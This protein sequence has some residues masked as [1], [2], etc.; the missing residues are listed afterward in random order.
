MAYQG[1]GIDENPDVDFPVVTIS[2]GQPGA[3]PA[4]METEITRKV[5]DALVGIEGLD[6]ITSTVSDG[7]SL[8]VAEFEVGTGIDGAMNDIRDAVGRIRQTLPADINEPAISNPNFAGQPFIT[9]TVSSDTRSVAELSDLIDDDITRSLLTVPGVGQVTRSGG[10][11]REIRVELDP[12]RLRAVGATVEHVNAQLRALNINLPGG[13]ARTGAQEQTIRTLGSVQRVEDLKRLQIALPNGSTARLD[14]LGTVSDDFAEVAQIARLNGKPVVGFNV[15]RAK[16]AA[17]VQTEEATV[18]HVEELKKTLPP[19]IRIEMVRTSADYTRSAFHASMDALVL[20]A[21]LAVIVIFL[22]LRNW[23]ATLISALAIPLS[24]IATFWV[25]QHL[26]YTLNGITLLGLTLVVGILV[27]DAIVDLENIYRH[28]AMGKSP[29]KAAFEATDEIG[30]AI[31]ATTAT[32]VAVFVPVA[33]MGGIPGMF[34]RS[35]G[36]TV[37]AAV[38]FS[39]L[40]ARTLTP[41]MAAYMLPSKVKHEEEGGSWYHRLYHRVLKLALAHRWWTMVGAVVIFVGSMALVPLIPKGFMSTGDIGQA[42]VAVELPAGSTLDQTDAV[43]QEVTRLLMERPET[44]LVFATAGAS[45]GAS[46][47]TS[48]GATVANSASVNVVL[49]PKHERA[50][51]LNEFEDALRPAFA[52][53]PGARVQFNQYGAAGGAKPVNILLRSSDPEALAKTSTQLLN[54]MRA[55]PELRDVTSSAAEMRPEVLIRPDPARAAEQGVS[56]MAVARVARLATQGEA[57]FNMPKFNAGDKQ[58]NIRVKLKDAVRYDLEAIGDLLVPGKAGMV[59]L[60]TVA[61]VSLGSGPVQIDRYDRARQVTFAANLTAGNLGAAVAKVQALPALKD[62]PPSVSQGTVGESK[63]MI[64]IFTQFALALG[65]AVL[66]IYAVLVLLFGGFMQPL[67]IMMALPLSIG[68]AMLGL[69]AF[70]KEMGMMALIGIVMLMGLVCKNSILLVEYAIKARHDGLPRTEALLRSGRD[71]LRPILMTTIAM[72]A[73]MMPIALAFGEGTERLSP[74]AV[75][76]I[77]GLITSTIFTLVVVPAAFTIVD[78]VQRFFW[79]LIGK[80]RP[81]A[82]AERPEEVVIS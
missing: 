6:H 20:G 80:P 24:I 75:A 52:Q 72:I 73:G 55:M 32:I 28:I 50:L 8:T 62:A 19:D 9:Y 7:V 34:F 11:N 54:E 13:S 57:D 66:L 60:R 5:E 76:V 3:A 29:L 33:F 44:E 35:F 37:A 18:K 77:G 51:S 82:A 68:G 42:V 81:E 40:V 2:I 46:R 79:R 58:I 64:D 61:D 74:M 23:Q 26:G 41:M 63:I 25:M 10:L 59:P 27:D 49:K 67:T 12:A 15:K 22:F 56:V 43:V 1:L 39:L 30:L 47:F 45:G 21:I 16:G 17:L 4:E 14:T 70:Q 78:D 69:L 53:I 36:L 31:V 38:L 48:G 71:R 65:T